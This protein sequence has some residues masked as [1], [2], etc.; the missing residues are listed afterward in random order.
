M[1]A[2]P[3]FWLLD[4]DLHSQDFPPVVGS[5]YVSPGLPHQ[6]PG[7][8]WQKSCFAY[9]PHEKVSRV[10]VP[11]SQ[12]WIPET[13]DGYT[14]L[15]KAANSVGR[16]EQELH[17]TWWL[18]TGP[19]L[20]KRPCIMVTE[21]SPPPPS[22]CKQHGLNCVT[23]QV[24]ELRGLNGGDFPDNTVRFGRQILMSLKNCLLRF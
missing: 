8:L 5:R 12:L 14:R 21:S 4:T 23:P 6:R 11:S 10:T 22:Q 3:H 9:P 24:C 13:S 7:T 19:Q 17:E 18:M 15:T 1:P 20:P 16:T 2:L